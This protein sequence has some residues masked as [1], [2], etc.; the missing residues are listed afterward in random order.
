MRFGMVAVW[1][2]DREYA[3]RLCEFLRRQN[4]FSSSVVSY[5]EPEQLKRAVDTRQVSVVVAGSPVAESEWLRDAAVLT[6][7]EERDAGEATVYKYQSAGEVFRVILGFRERNALSGAGTCRPAAKIRGI[8]SPLG[9]CLKTSLGLVM[10]CLPAEEKRCLFLSLEAH[11]GFRTLFGR[12]YPMDLS[13]LFTAVRQK[14]NVPAL[15]AET[16]QSFGKLQ[17]IPPVIWPEDIR[18]AERGELRELLHMPAQDGG[19]D[20]IILDVGTDLA[21]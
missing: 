14:G 10:G 9:G 19:F 3:L 12:Q 6:L 11:S 21:R 2:Q 18:E 16:I 1:D 15:L 5:S 20:E 17:Y 4:G 7:T 13:D 8:Y